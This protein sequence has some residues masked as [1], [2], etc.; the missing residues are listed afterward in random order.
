MPPPSESALTASPAWGPAVASGDARPDP[1]DDLVADRVASLGPVVGGR[2]AVEA[3]A[4]EHHLV[5]DGCCRFPDVEL[6][7]VHADAA[8]DAVAC[9]VEP[10]V[11]PA[12]GMAW[13]AVA[14][15]QRHEHQPG[16]VLGGIGVTVKKTLP[17]PDV[18]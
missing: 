13:D 11:G 10:D 7:L 6:E 5:A 17:S 3:V 14:V 4:E 15:A 12:R 16:R 18:L 8:G 9:A 1:G 2:A